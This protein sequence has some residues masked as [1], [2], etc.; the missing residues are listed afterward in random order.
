MRLLACLPLLALTVMGSTDP[1]RLEVSPRTGLVP[2]T[3]R[4]K[5]T[6]EPNY[7]NSEMCLWWDNADGDFGR[8]CRTLDQYT[9][10]TH[11]FTMWLRTPG[12]YEFEADVK[13]GP[14]VFRTPQISVE[15]R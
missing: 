3:V 11:W 10:R 12:V 5:V 15:L 6:L 9:P 8:T 1:I 14:T 2:M 4:A 13:Q 7:L